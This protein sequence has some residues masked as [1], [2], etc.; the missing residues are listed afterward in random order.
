MST[1]FAAAF[2]AAK[3]KQAHFLLSK[4]AQDFKPRD[5]AAVKTD[6]AYERFKNIR[7]GWTD[8]VV[9]CPACHSGR[10]Y[11]LN[12]RLMW[13][14]RKCGRQ[15]SVTSGTIFAARKASFQTILHA[16]S[17]RLH[18]SQNILQTCHTLG[19]QYKTA[20]AWAFKFRTLLGNKVVARVQDSRWPY[21][22]SDRSAA[23]DLVKIVNGILPRELPEQKRADVA[24]EMILGVLSGEIDEADLHASAIKYIR[25]YHR[26]YENHFRDISFDA[27]L[28]GDGQNFHDIISED[29]A[30][31]AWDRFI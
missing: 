4:A 22:N 20:Y 11:E 2:E 17:L 24:Q 31:D 19:V 5:A 1:A 30:I 10:P 13:R 23:A 9:E 7:F 16:V 3:E 15:F 29:T 26:G 6:E 8:G 12:S 21:L 14:C 27:R 28:G 25:K 18:D